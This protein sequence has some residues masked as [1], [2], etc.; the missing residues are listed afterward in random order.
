MKNEGGFTDAEL[1]SICRDIYIDHYERRQIPDLALVIEAMNAVLSVVHAINAGSLHNYFSELSGKIKAELLLDNPDLRKCRLWIA[2]YHCYFRAN[3]A[4]QSRFGT[5]LKDSIVELLEQE[6][7]RHLSRSDLFTVA[8]IQ[9]LDFCAIFE[10][11]RSEPTCPHW[12][13]VAPYSD[14][15]ESINEAW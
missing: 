7:P 9:E 8:I 12:G 10:S 5:S 2:S 6:L 1:A 3:C 13:R 4:S 15:A 11:P 14:N